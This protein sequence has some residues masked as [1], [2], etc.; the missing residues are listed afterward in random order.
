MMR[1]DTQGQHAQPPAHLAP[2]ET[3]AGRSCA[4]R[5]MK[6]VRR[7][8]KVLSSAGGGAPA[9]V[10]RPAQPNR[11]EKGGSTTNRRRARTQTQHSTAVHLGKFWACAELH[12]AQQARTAEASSTGSADKQL[13]AL[14]KHPVMNQS[15]LTSGS[16]LHHSGQGRPAAASC[17]HPQLNLAPDGDR[18]HAASVAPQPSVQALV[19]HGLHHPNHQPRSDSACAQ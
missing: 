18:S 14:S 10:Q 15:Q 19:T 2:Q 16:A 6:T 12:T 8:L 17:Q 4:Q 9:R 1:G 5:A 3:C 13:R 7:S 11:N